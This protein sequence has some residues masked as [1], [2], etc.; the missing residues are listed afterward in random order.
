MDNQLAVAKFLGKNQRNY[1][2]KDQEDGHQTRWVG[3]DGKDTGHN[4]VV[5]S[6]C[7]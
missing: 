3:Y 6:S 1:G 7:K 4:S 2:A 5:V